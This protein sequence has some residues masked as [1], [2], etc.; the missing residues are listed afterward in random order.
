MRYKMKNEDDYINNK[1]IKSAKYVPDRKDPLDCLSGVISKKKKSKSILNI[2]IDNIKVFFIHRKIK[3]DRKK[4]EK[5]LR[6]MTRSQLKEISLK[7]YSDYYKYLY[8][9][10]KADHDKL[11]D[12]L[13]YYDVPDQS[14]PYS[15]LDP[16]YSSYHPLGFFATEIEAILSYSVLKKEIREFQE[17]KKVEDLY[18][19]TD[20]ENDFEKKSKNGLDAIVSLSYIVFY[21]KNVSPLFKKIHKDNID[22]ALMEMILNIDFN[23]LPFSEL[24]FKVALATK[25]LMTKENIDFL[26]N[27]KKI[28][29]IN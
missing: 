27:N 29:K 16:E 20:Q 2:L 7:E 3:K 10:K 28:G 18:K 6:K 17:N 22:L 8:V 15:K 12:L 1:F 14:N 9:S 11:K 24:D 23:N 25:G 4:V 13:I 5:S 19:I 21:G 26:F